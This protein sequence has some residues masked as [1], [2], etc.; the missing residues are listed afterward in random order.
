VPVYFYV[1]YTAADSPGLTATYTVTVA[2]GGTT[3][4]TRN[5]T[6]TSASS[7]SANAGGSDVTN[8]LGPGI[9]VGQILTQTV[10]YKYGNNTDISFQPLGI[11]NFPD[12]VFRLVGNEITNI[13]GYASGAGK[14][15]TGIAIGDH[16][17]LYWPGSSV[18]DSGTE[19]TMVYYWEVLTA[20][21]ASAL[22]PWADATSGTQYK[23]LYK[24]TESVLPA[25]G[26]AALSVTKTVDPV[27]LR[28]TTTDGGYG[29]G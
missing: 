23:Y 20:G 6:V 10:V 8:T 19:F 25:A 16:D 12:A 24:T 28:A 26:A 7:I 13:A 2:S 9:Y 14:A 22:R 18:P 21:T 11:S 1:D 17:K 5:G 15:P 29:P 4:A 3:L 27:W